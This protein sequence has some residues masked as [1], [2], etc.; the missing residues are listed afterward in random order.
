MQSQKKEAAAAE[1]KPR[2]TAGEIYDILEL[3]ALCATVIIL[4][5][6]FAIRMTVVNQH[7]MEQTLIEGDYML[8][9]D[10]FYT[11][12]TG[13][14]VVVQN[15]SLPNHAEPLVKRVIAVGGDT[16]NINYRNWCVTVTHNGEKRI[17]EEEYMYLDPTKSLVV[18][19]WWDT[20]E[21][22]GS[23][24]YNIPEGYVFVMGD[25]RHV[26][27]DSRLSEVG[28]IPESCV[29][30]HVFMRVFPFSKIGLVN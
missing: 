6:T 19:D 21:P 11:P 14:I 7:S 8:V 29:V 22:D 15:P 24:T 4:I 17:L 1:K 23:Y 13:D 3:V 2:D 9:S 10:L 12:K 28:L 30:G 27:A 25:N 20:I 16:L 5:Y 26:S 18:A